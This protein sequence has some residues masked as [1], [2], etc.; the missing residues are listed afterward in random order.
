[1]SRPDS[2]V[3][4]WSGSPFVVATWCINFGNHCSSKPHVCTG[5]DIVA[6]SVGGFCS[7]GLVCCW[8]FRVL[9]AA[10]SAEVASTW[11]NVVLVL[12]EGR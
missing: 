10:M 6:C 2:V 8:F 5:I 1:M 4:G 7:D 12:E 11:A 3:D 9:T